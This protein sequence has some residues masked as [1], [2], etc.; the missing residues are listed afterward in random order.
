METPLSTRAMDESSDSASQDGWDQVAQDLLKL[1]QEDSD[2]TAVCDACRSASTCSSH[3][4]QPPELG[5]TRAWWAELIKSHCQDF[6]HMR[7]ASV[8][9]SLKK[10][11]VISAC[12]G[13]FAEGEA[14]KASN[15]ETVQKEQLYMLRNTTQHNHSLYYSIMSCYDYM[16]LFAQ[17]NVDFHKFSYYVPSHTGAHMT[18]IRD[19]G[20]FILSRIILSNHQYH[21]HSSWDCGTL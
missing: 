8:L 9:N 3:D 20:M 2:E 15:K 4:D 21:I 14:L 12:S 10:V 13:I 18:D 16:N 1:S 11:S 7:T 19:M 6:V 5:R 17:D